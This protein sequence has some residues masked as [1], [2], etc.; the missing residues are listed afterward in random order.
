MRIFYKLLGISATIILANIALISCQSKCEFTTQDA[1]KES[2]QLNDSIYNRIFGSKSC[3]PQKLILRLPVNVNL[4][5]EK[6]NKILNKTSYTPQ[7]TTL[8]TFSN[9]YKNFDI[10]RLDEYGNGFFYTKKDTCI[11]WK[12]SNG[13]KQQVIYL[14]MER[15]LQIHN[16]NIKSVIF[17]VSLPLEM[18]EAGVDITLERYV[19]NTDTSKVG[20]I[21]YFNFNKQYPILKNLLKQKEKGRININ[22]AFQEGKQVQPNIKRELLE[23][24]KISGIH[25]ERSLEKMIKEKYEKTYLDTAESP[26]CEISK[27]LIK[28]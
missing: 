4:K 6:Q 23:I 10:S 25:I 17:L 5:T 28:L 8:V 14:S 11:A 18:K 19:R 16:N 22:D 9:K 21:S 1:Q 24:S 20:L 13:N 3:S 7:I 15:N 2:V 27:D 26:A 12:W